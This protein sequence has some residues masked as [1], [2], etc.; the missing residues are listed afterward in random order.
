MAPRDNKSHVRSHYELEDD[1]HVNT[2]SLESMVIFSST[3][4]ETFLF[5]V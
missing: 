3:V 1:L 5:Y 4:N 2:G